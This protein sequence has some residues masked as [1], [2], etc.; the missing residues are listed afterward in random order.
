MTGLPN[1]LSQL[2]PNARRE[3]LA[4]MLA[5]RAAAEGVLAPC[6]YGQ[7]S[8]W[9]MHQLAPESAV[10]NVAMGWRLR[11]AV[12]VPAMR[13]AFQ[14]LVDRHEVLRTTYEGKA[15]EPWQRVHSTLP[16][17]F[18]ARDVGLIDEHELRM[19]MTKD[20][21]QP[22]DLENGPVL[23]ARLFSRHATDHALLLTIHHIACDLW[24]VEALL[25]DLRVLYER[26]SKAV[27]A[28]GVPPIAAGLY[29]DFVAWQR[30][31]IDGPEGEAHWN[32][33]HEK[34]SGTLPRLELPTDR[35]RPSV[36]SFAGSG[37]AFAVPPN[38]VNDLRQ[39]AAAEGT[40][41]FTV[42]LAA[43]QALL[44]R[45]SGQDDIIVGSPATGR[46]R[47][48]FESTAGYFV[49]PIVFR[50]DA[51][52][53]P[54][55][56]DL[57]ARARADVLGS[58]DHQDYPFPLLVEKLHVNRDVSR[59]P[60]ADTYFVWDKMRGPAEDH[61]AADRNGEIGPAKIDWQDLSL[62]SFTLTQIG[63]PSDIA[64]L[65]WE[66]GQ[67]ISVNLGYSTDLFDRS[68][69]ERMGRH[70]LV[71]LRGI[72]ADPECRISKLPMATPDESESM[73][74]AMPSPSLAA[75]ARSALSLHQRFEQHARQRPDAVAVTCAGEHLTYRELDERANALAARLRQYGVGRECVVGLYVERNLDMVVAILGV[76]KAG[77]AYL[78]I[79][80]AYPDDRIA[81]MLEDAGVS[82]LI[83]QRSLDEASQKFAATRVF[84]DDPA[85]ADLDTRQV[86]G[87]SR[88]D[89]LAYVIYT[90]GS[91]GRPKGVMVTH[92]NVT[93]L[94]DATAHWFQF[95]EADVWSLFHSIAFDFSVWELWG[96]LLH[97]ARV[98]IVPYAVS[99]SPEEM[100]DLLVAERVTMLSQTPSAFRQVIAADGIRRS[101]SD[102]SLRFVVFG[103]EALDVAMLRPW[104]ERHGDAHPRLVNMFG[105]TETTVHVTYRPITAD[106]LNQRVRSPIG[107][108]IPDL[109]LLVLDAAGQPVPPGVPGEL[110]V[111]GAGV[112]RGYLN[113]PELTAERFLHDPTSS[114]SAAR[115]Y[116]T[117]D[118]V[119]LG[120]DGQLEY[121]GR[122]DAQIKLRGFRIELGE[123]EAA[124][125]H[126]PAV[127]NCAVVLR[128]DSP[129]DARLVAYVVFR[130]GI[131][132]SGGDMQATLKVALPDYMVPTAFVRMSALPL[133]SN[134][135][136]DVKALPGVD[137]AES[138]SAR[139]LVSPRTDVEREIA[140]EWARLLK[141]DRVSVDDDFFELG[142]HSILATALARWLREHFSVD[143]PVYAVFDA[144]TVIGMAD[145]V[146]AIRAESAKPVA[147]DDGTREEIEL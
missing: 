60:L 99:R 116:R 147:S 48:E 91:T 4:R 105:I 26:E 23:R 100:L 86:D 82:T 54:T 10:Y 9:F 73:L 137:Q 144:P 8:L 140:A 83:T 130:A 13:R 145:R 120:A 41:L 3:L 141:I 108:A 28:M 42:F 77:G 125:A 37:V 79:D 122:I 106:D 55:F 61:G 131:E 103:G 15:G 6:S 135:K 34:L 111:A 36:Q 139:P 146:Q 72:L 27:V 2:T 101:T 71:L 29:R 25:K 1:D 104:I 33:W 7:R 143:F 87:E 114:N 96:A 24:S 80:R 58:L 46:S 19:V 20:A 16:V 56:R 17:G 67:T 102:L 94:F 66:M 59:S 50:C 68:T 53:D 76:L 133:T 118:R 78:P 47:S 45:Y 127:E 14:A 5:E 124:L 92:R 90:S 126:H 121:L 64:V 44:V 119:R 35:P 142:G 74:R 85:P 88:L 22:F 70:Y 129:G 97:G 93:R 107:V 51:S 123:I 63:T 32:Y 128:E 113:R 31:M 65:V 132:A 98:V 117:G 69:I 57:V 138:I 136:L 115:L 81:F 43:F 30:A 134:H 89:D 40:T 18:E 21:G 12:D 112:A 109:R 49:N 75:D 38:V 110:Y 84:V 39:L 62:E 95:R 11:S 52:D